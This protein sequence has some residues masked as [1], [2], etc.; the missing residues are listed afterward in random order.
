LIKN[1]IDMKK[2]LVIIIPLMLISA[3]SLDTLF[4]IVTPKQDALLSQ[5]LVKFIIVDDATGMALGKKSIK[6]DAG[7]VMP[8]NYF[9]ND[10]PAGERVFVI[11]N[12]VAGSGEEYDWVLEDNATENAIIFSRRKFVAQKIAT[13]WKFVIRGNRILMK[14]I[15]TGNYLKINSEGQFSQVGVA[16]ASHWK[17][18][19]AF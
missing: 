6:Y 19:H 12:K 11:H 17:F 10:A 5:N 7:K 4:S 9:T 3:I 18:I 16:S 2:L 13:H 8:I 14:N 15:R 1:T